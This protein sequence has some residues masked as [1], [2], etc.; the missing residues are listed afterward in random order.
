MLQN[1]NQPGTSVW[2]GYRQ[3]ANFYSLLQNQVQFS[4]DQNLAAGNVNGP[5][6]NGMTVD[7]FA[8]VL[9]TDWYQLTLKDLCRVT[10]TWNSPRWASD[11]EGGNASPGLA[12][13]HHPLQRR[14]RVPA[15]GRRPAPQHA[16]RGD[17]PQVTESW[18]GPAPATGS[19]H[20]PLL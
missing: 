20:P 9:D 8:D 1:S 10:G 7:A 5:K 19:G 3:Q 11:I 18:P 12:V 17:R 15:A 16:G 6:W 13:R 2:T 4:G 14:A